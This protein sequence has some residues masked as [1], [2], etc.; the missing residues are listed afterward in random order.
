MTVSAQ[1][2]AASV[3]DLGLGDLLREQ[4]QTQT[5]AAR[6]SALKNEGADQAVLSMSPAT[7]ALF[8][9]LGGGNDLLG[10]GKS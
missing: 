7:H 1:N 5:E 3:T 9:F 6:Q 8:S 2:Y 4:T 10:M